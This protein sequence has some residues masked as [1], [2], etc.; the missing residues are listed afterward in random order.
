MVGSIFE[1]NS[2]IGHWNAVVTM[3]LRAPGYLYYILHSHAPKR[4]STVDDA[5]ASGVIAESTTQSI[6]IV[7][8][9]ICRRLQTR[10]VERI[11]W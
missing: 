9:R 6:K 5:S 4:A 10:T 1:S 11:A 2:G 7:L 8:R 3:T